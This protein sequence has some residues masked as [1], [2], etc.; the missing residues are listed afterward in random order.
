[1]FLMT[2]TTQVIPLGFQLMLVMKRENELPDE[3]Q[4]GTDN[5]EILKSTLFYQLKNNVKKTIKGLL[6]IQQRY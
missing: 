5:S 1:M 2:P 4:R 3:I 6:L